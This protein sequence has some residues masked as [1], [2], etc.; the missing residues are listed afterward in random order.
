MQSNISQFLEVFRVA[1]LGNDTF[2]ED[3]C[4]IVLDKTNFPVEKHCVV[5]KNSSV[6]IKADP[7]MK[8]EIMLC[9]DEILEAV[10]TKYPHKNIQDIF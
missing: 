1:V 8:T 10:R 3:V 6:Y 4:S 9:R 5:S 7:Y 2:R